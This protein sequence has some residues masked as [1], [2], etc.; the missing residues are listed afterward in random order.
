ME[1]PLFAP[2]GMELLVIDCEIEPSLE[3]YKTPK[4]RSLQGIF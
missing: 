3:L 2:Q 4:T 1:E